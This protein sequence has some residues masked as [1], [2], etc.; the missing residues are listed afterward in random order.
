MPKDI[1]LREALQRIALLAD[2]ESDEYKAFAQPYLRMG[3]KPSGWRIA[4]E[5]RRIANDAVGSEPL[6]TD[7]EMP[8]RVEGDE[9]ECPWCHTIHEMP[10]WV[11]TYHTFDCD[12]GGRFQSEKTTVLVSRPMELMR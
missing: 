10:K 5:M 3:D 1:R 9:P 12:C 7:S 8:E 2:T 6:A 4:E 11:E